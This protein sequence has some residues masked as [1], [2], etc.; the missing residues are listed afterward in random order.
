MNEERACSVGGQ[1]DMRRL[2]FPHP[3]ICFR[4]PCWLHVNVDKRILHRLCV[5]VSTKLHLCA[6]GRGAGIWGRVGGGGGAGGGKG[7]CPGGRRG[8]G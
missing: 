1:C 6:G 8:G 3:L 5:S 4:P 2:K 7:E